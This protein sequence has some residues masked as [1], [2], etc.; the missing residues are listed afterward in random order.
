MDEVYFDSS[1]DIRWLI[2]VLKYFFPFL[3]CSL[4]Q[5]STQYLYEEQFERKFY[6][7]QILLIKDLF[8]YFI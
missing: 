2:N 1:L 5:F 7:D 8:Q 4:F 6:G 3:V